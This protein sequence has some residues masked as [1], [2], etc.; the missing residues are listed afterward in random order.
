MLIIDIIRL[1]RLRKVENK[2]QNL[3]TK[4]RQLISKLEWSNML[5]AIY[6]DNYVNVE[7]SAT[8]SYDHSYGQSDDVVVAIEETKF[9]A[10]QTKVSS[11]STYTPS[12]HACVIE[13]L[14]DLE[15]DNLPE[16]LQENIIVESK[17]VEVIQPDSNVVKVVNKTNAAKV[18]EIQPS[19]KISDELNEET[20]V[21]SED[22]NEIIATLDVRIVSVDFDKE[23]VFVCV[24]D[25]SQLQKGIPNVLPVGADKEYLEKLN[26][27]ERCVMTIYSN[28]VTS[29]LLENGVAI[30]C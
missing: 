23:E 30:A 26:P 15:T 28:G 21:N 14:E 12:K 19:S 17:K 1:Y 11:K 8:F 27:G 24:L 2:I 6:K 29:F 22:E 9:E 4:K 20:H 5:P 3:A 10:I 13:T 25:E 18:V 16:L 7:L